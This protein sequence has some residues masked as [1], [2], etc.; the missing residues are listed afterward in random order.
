MIHLFIYLFS[1]SLFAQVY[2][3]EELVQKAQGYYPELAAKEFEIASSKALMKQAKKW[4]NPFLTYQGGEIRSDGQRGSVLD[5]TLSQPIPWPGKRRLRFKAQEEIFHLSEISQE[6]I[7]ISFTHRVYLLGIQLAALQELQGHQLERKK[8]FQLI[9]KSLKI[10]PQISPRQKVDQ[11]LINSQIT[12]IEKS[13][14]EILSQKESLLRELSLLSNTN[15]Q[16]ID[17]S[18]KKLPEMLNRDKVMTFLDESPRAKYWKGGEKLA[19]IRVE[20]ARIESRPDI[21][22]GVNYR[23]EGIDPKNHFYHAQVSFVLP[24][25]DQGQI[26]AES[27]RALSFKLKAENSREKHELMAAVY[28]N[29]AHLEAAQKALDLFKFNELSLM[30][31]QFKEAEDSFRKGL[32]DAISFLQVDS[33]V[34]ELIDQVYFTRVE[35]LSAHSSLKQLVGLLPELH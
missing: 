15:L 5:L 3:M 22:L 8:R 11:N 10:R 9:E 18:W 23:R 17:F 31:N 35:Y 33:Q 19:S 32:I 6:E 26:A 14:L 28:K 12:L 7:K 25:L 29:Y 2:S 24:L 16:K 13:M 1:S 21:L 27:A 4:G 30:E 20:E 34:H